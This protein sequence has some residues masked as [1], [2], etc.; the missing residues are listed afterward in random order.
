MDFE[1]CAGYRLNTEKINNLENVMV[2]REEEQE[3][4]TNR[5][6]LRLDKMEEE[7]HKKFEHIEKRFD[8]FQNKFDNFESKIPKIFNDIVI[9]QMGRFFKWFVVV[10][11]GSGFVLYLKDYVIIFFQNIFGG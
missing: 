5:L 11:I 6:V 2:M 3:R 4:T 1:N 7:T 9:Y 10:V 8:D